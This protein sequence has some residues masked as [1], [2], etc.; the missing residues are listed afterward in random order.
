[1]SLRYSYAMSPMLK[2]GSYHCDGSNGRNVL[3]ID[4]ER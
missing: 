3:D 1:M 2:G 4:D